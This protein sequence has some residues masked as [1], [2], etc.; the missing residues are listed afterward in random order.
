MLQTD[1]KIVEI[2]LKE[3]VENNNPLL[4]H[5]KISYPNSSIAQESNTIFVG[6]ADY[7][8]GDNG[9]DF[10]AGTDLV[11]IL[12]VTKKRPNKMGK[13]TDKQIYDE[14][15]HIIKTV[16]LEIRRIL[17]LEENIQILGNKPRFRNIT[18][19]YSNNYVINRGH[20][21]L[22]LKVIDEITDYSEQFERVC[23]ILLEDI[24]EE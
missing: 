14:S 15:K 16:F 23:N 20:M 9:F 2:L 21:M 6:V 18:P 24:I 7:E 8:A 13:K 11:D 12:V 22:Q 10:D 4:Q 17:Q 19:E 3:K 5:F 1:E